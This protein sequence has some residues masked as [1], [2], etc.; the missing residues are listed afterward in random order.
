MRIAKRPSLLPA[1]DLC[2]DGGEVPQLDG[3]QSIVAKAQ[4]FGCVQIRKRI[5]TRRKLAKL[6]GHVNGVCER[7]DVAL[8]I[9]CNFTGC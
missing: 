7:H 2:V 3:L 1:V 5:H 6:I 4:P 9:C 8:A